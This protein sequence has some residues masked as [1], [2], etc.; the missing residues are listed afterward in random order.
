MKQTNALTLSNSNALP[1][2]GTKFDTPTFNIFDDEATGTIFIHGKTYPYICDPHV[3]KLHLWQQ[4]PN[5]S[6]L[7][8]LTEK[9]PFRFN[10]TQ[11]VVLE[12]IDLLKPAI[13]LNV[14]HNLYNMAELAPDQM[15]YVDML[16]NL[17]NQLNTP[18]RQFLFNVFLNKEI[19][20]AFVT[21][22][23][24]INHH[25]AWKG[26]LLVHS[27]E[28]A[29]MVSQLART[30]MTPVEAEATI[31]SALLHDIGK[32]RTFQENGHWSELGHYVS[33]DALSL[34]ILAP[35]L[36]ELEKQWR[37]GAHLVRHILGWDR[38]QKIFPAFPGTQ[39]MKMCDQFSTALELREATFKGKPNW[40]RH[41]RHEG[42][43]TQ[44]FLRLPQ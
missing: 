11:S 41:A 8:R 2:W 17:I 4:T 14:A 16:F 29:L 3:M 24:S 25:H 26:G 18:L 33:H 42:N 36:A 44:R 13:P 20:K 5:V 23:A 31:V 35:Y 7:V 27:V 15:R 28:S 30:W 19:A 21:V 6:V 22:N 9:I 38:K 12:S 32:T 10:H 37:T 34:E 43:N 39:L 40:H 1:A